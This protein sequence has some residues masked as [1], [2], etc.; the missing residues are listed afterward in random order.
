MFYF[1]LEQYI[2]CHRAPLTP[3]PFDPRQIEESDWEAREVAVVIEKQFS[4]TDQ[5]A[6]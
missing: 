6:Q 2:T 5:T 1:I 4:E 3:K